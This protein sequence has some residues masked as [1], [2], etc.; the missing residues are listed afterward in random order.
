MNYMHQLF[1][2]RIRYAYPLYFFQKIIDY[3]KID[4]EYNE[5][6][7]FKAI[8][9]EGALKNVKQ[10]GFE[11]HTHEVQGQT[12]T[13]DNFVMYWSLL[14][15]LEQAGF[16]RWYWHFNH[17]GK[18]TSKRTGRGRTCCYEMVYININFINM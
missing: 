17:F 1:V 9:E 11:T 16:R 15:K 3:L 6:D 8:F 12:T 10:F 7:T 2:I 18:Y 14:D 5:W 13:V 4:I